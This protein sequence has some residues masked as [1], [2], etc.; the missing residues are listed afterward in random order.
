MTTSLKN[1]KT[2]NKKVS[3]VP[4]KR[5]IGTKK[6]TL[7]VGDICELKITAL[8]PN[9]IGIDELT[10]PYAVFVP[11]GNYVQLLKPKF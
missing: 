10:Y 5:S 9:N 2:P 4:M 6:K 11:N 1:Q 3:N 7:S 8:A